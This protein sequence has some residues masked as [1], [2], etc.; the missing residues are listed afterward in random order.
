MSDIAATFQNAGKA[1]KDISRADRQGLAV[2]DE[3]DKGKVKAAGV[4]EAKNWNGRLQAP[5][6]ELE[7]IEKAIREGKS[8][9]KISIM[10]NNINWLL[11]FS[12]A[13][14]KKGPWFELENANKKINL[15][16]KYGYNDEDN[17]KKGP[18]SRI[19]LS[20]IPSLRILSIDLGHRHAAACAVWETI[21]LGKLKEL[22]KENGTPP[23]KNHI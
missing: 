16:L 7:R 17:R 1:V 20:R 12:A 3:T 21:S 8:K 9:D 4:F 18:N 6:N 19:I 11:S 15:S 23:L 22:C 5:R 13:V 14:E 10:T 2:A